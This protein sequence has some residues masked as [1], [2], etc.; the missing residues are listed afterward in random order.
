M[1]KQASTTYVQVPQGPEESPRSLETGLEGPLQA[2]PS[3]G[4]TP[5]QA[6]AP[7]ELPSGETMSTFNHWTISPGLLHVLFYK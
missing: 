4:L 7:W 5:P 3:P 6:P 1:R 2:P